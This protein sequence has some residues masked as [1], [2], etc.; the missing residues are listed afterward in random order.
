[1]IGIYKI[2]NLVT[3]EIYIGQG[4]EV[5]RRMVSHLKDEKHVGKKLIQSI[6]KYGPTNF[7]FQII[8]LCEKEQLDEKETYWIKY[9]DS[10]NNGL[11]MDEGGNKHKGNS[12]GTG[13]HWTLSA[14]ARENIR[15]GVLKSMTPERIKKA[16]DSHRGKVHDWSNTDTSK[17][18]KSTL[19]KHRVYDNKD[20]NIYHYE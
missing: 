15:Q 4:V 16:A 10:F 2:T 3:N 9:Y 6:K 12:N 5:E 14:E 17:M 8:E 1:M 19:G 11:N 20:K 13:K 18:G 7:V